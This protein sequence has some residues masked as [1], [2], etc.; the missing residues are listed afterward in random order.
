[1]DGTNGRMNGRMENLTIY[2][3]SSPIRAA[4]LLQKRKL[5]SNKLK[6]YIVEQGKGTDDHFMT[7]GDWFMTFGRY[8]FCPIARGSL[9]VYL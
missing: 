4:P 5:K 3:T 6:N 7:L 1:M 8:C 2:R 9:T